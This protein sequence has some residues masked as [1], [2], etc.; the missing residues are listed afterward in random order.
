MDKR[1]TLYL[2]LGYPGAGKTTTAKLISELTG[3]VHLWADKIRR[4]RYGTPTYSHQEN[5]EL[6]AHVNEVADELLAGGQSVVYDTNFNFY[7]DR[8]RLRK[9]ACKHG[10]RTIVVWVRTPKETAKSRATEGAHLQD[11]RLLGDM[12]PEH[13]ERMARNLQEPR[14]RE[15]VLQLDGTKVTKTVVASLIHVSH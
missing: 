12:P 13:F 3:A 11:T 2:M 5:I 15:T 7:R 6:Y 4:E 8:Q 1:L 10:A 9:I 14:R